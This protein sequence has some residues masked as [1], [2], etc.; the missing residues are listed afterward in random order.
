MVENIEF[1]NFRGFKKLCLK[2]VKPITLISG[3]NNA[4]KSSVLDGI[5]LYFDHVAPESF[6]K[7]NLFRNLPAGIDGSQ[8]WEPV[9]NNL[10]TSKDMCISVELSGQKTK[11]CYSKDMSFI[12]PDN[13]QTPQD[14][15]AQFVSSAKQSYTLKFCF[16]KGDYAETGH[17]VA[18]QSG[19]MRNI[20]TTLP[21]N[22]IEAMPFTQYINSIII[23]NENVVI[24][25]I[26]KMELSGQ[27][28]KIIR[29]LRLLDSDVEDVSTISINGQ[30]QL[31]IRTKENLLPL[32]LAGDGLN[33]L[34]FIV[35]AIMTNP[36]AII[37][38]DEI[39]AGFHYSM[40]PKLW[41]VI[42]SA[43]RDSSC[44]IIATTH[45]YE[46][47]VGAISGVESSNRSDDFCY[48]RLDQK[49]DNVAAYRY[50]DELLRTAIDA[51]M[52][53]R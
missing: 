10:D 25:R 2:D 17:L 19:V 26:G 24:D 20:E 45:S 40:F 11:L 37:L 43:A 7:I 33:K 27:K 3:K 47:I 41:E 21:G 13:A 30:A 44:Q 5:F 29:I 53:V 16:S 23:N 28:D 15:L 49:D 22:E 46:C 52:E 36:N 12:P 51:D 9:F 32:K 1:E 18:S 42:V 4:G 50:S 34:L 31:Y 14:V 48:F 38:I 8:M 39:D 35:L 6:R